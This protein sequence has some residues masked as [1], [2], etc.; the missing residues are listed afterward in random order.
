MFSHFSNEFKIFLILFT[1]FFVSAS[2]NIESIDGVTHYFLSKKIVLE[3][4]IYFEPSEQKVLGMPLSLNNK[5]YKYYP[6]YNP[7]YAILV[8]PIVIF[9]TALRNFIRTPLPEW[10]LES[11]YMIVFLANLFNAFVIGL[12]AIQMY[13]ISK[14]Y[15]S[16]KKILRLLPFII[17]AEVI[18]TNLIIQA[19]AH[20]A[21]PLFLLFLLSS[22][23]HLNQWI[24]HDRKSNLVFF[25][26][27]FSLTAMV[28]NATFVLMIPP[29]FLYVFLHHKLNMKKFILLGLTFVPS[30]L[31]QM[32]WN[33]VRFGGIFSTGY[34][35]QSFAIYVF[36]F[37]QFIQN[38]Y[39]MTF[40]PNKGIFIYNPIL[41]L[42]P[43]AV[44]IILRK[45]VYEKRRPFV[46][47]FLLVSFILLVNYSL[48]S[49]WHG[50]VSFGPRYL[51]PII[52]T[53]LIVI[54]SCLSEV[55]KRVEVT[56]IT[57]LLVVGLLVQIPGMLI[58]NFSLIFLAPNYCQQY[59]Q[60]YFN[61]RCSPIKVGWSHL[62]KRRVKETMT[63]IG[64]GKK[65][66]DTISIN[67]PNPPTI[68]R[69][70]YP[71]PLFDKFSIYKT[72]NYKISKQMMNDIYSFTL[73]IWW[74]KGILYKNVF[75]R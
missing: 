34:M 58:P 53:G 52:V 62:L 51:L 75:N 21:H 40:A 19:H 56:L 68:F 45:K 32:G 67:Y 1:I 13:R 5:N 44:F 64:I 39:G 36:S 4:K 43:I 50:D 46:L 57:V 55:K 20:F 72:S 26:L 11:D 9:D 69:T 47:F 35:E 31:L 16:S 29:L 25:T 12:V 65:A 74:I 66:P 28:Y 30:I 18:S 7:G 70:I 15:I 8:S 23:I 71:D 59:E 41:I 17:I 49:F 60:N 33:F 3:H 42:A 14:L 61:W 63:T 2:G 22:F 54:N 24:K 27:Y 73:D 48:V 37:K 38:L 6:V 10:P